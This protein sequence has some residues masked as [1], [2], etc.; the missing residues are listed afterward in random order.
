MREIMSFV[1]T[2]YRK[3]LYLAH[4]GIVFLLLCSIAYTPVVFALQ[5]SPKN[6]DKIESQVKVESQEKIPSTEDKSQPSSPPKNKP[7]SQPQKEAIPGKGDNVDTEQTTDVG[8]LLDQAENLNE[9][10][11]TSEESVP[12]NKEQTANEKENIDSD[13]ADVNYEEPVET[14]LADDSLALFEEE[15]EKLNEKVISLSRSPEDYGELYSRLRPVLEE[16]ISILFDKVA[17]PNIDLRLL[18]QVENNEEFQTLFS[19]I[20]EI[21]NFFLLRQ[22]LFD[23]ATPEFRSLVT[24][25]KLNGISEAKLELHYIKLQSFLILKATFQRVFEVPYRFTSAPVDII[26]SILLIIFA[27][28]LLKTWWAWAKTGLPQAR[29]KILSIRPRTT[30]KVR[31]AR[32][33]WYFE[34]TR[35]PIEWLIFINFVLNSIDILQLP[36]LIDIL[37][38]ITLWVCLTYFAF[39]FLS[40]MIERGKQNVLKNISKGQ[41]ASLKIAVWWAGWHILAFQLM[42]ILIPYGTI[43][44]WLETLFL[45]LILP[46]YVFF[47]YQWREDCFTF[48]DEERDTPD[49]IVKIVA[50]R[51]GIRGF[52]NANIALVFALYFYFSS[53]FLNL[54]SKVE[55]GRRITAEI[56]RKKLLND[57]TV[58]LDKAK[59][60]EHL[61]PKLNELLTNSKNS[62]VESVLAGPLEKILEMVE[63]HERSHV[64]IVGERGIGKTHFLEQLATKHQNSLILSCTEDFNQF[65]ES[66]QKQLGIETENPNT[67]DIIKAI[68]E[69]SIDLILLDNCHR[70]LTPTISGQ[71]EIRRLYGWINEL[72][73]L[74][75]WVF[76][77][78]HSS[79]NL[80]TALGIATGFYSN[81]IELK[82]WTEDQVTEL[83]ETRLKEADIEV[84]FSQLVIP[85]QLADIDDDSLETRNQTGIY[86]IIWGYADGNPAV[87]C[88]TFADALSIEND[89]YIVRLPEYPETKIMEGFDINTLLVLRVI[90]Q[91]GRCSVN[92]IVQNLRLHELIVNSAISACVAQGIIEQIGGRY[93]ISWLWFR[94]VSKFLARQ[95]LLSR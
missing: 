57:N 25:S 78:D 19:Q 77:F 8:S 4:F 1:K 75:L 45:F 86:R 10:T 56:Y 51:T 6:N 94:N 65:I 24:S 64:A 47:I 76:T 44:S 73:G 48:I 7:Q 30:G 22:K 80:L 46:I 84:D 54:I 21:K 50:Q 74:A 9:E 41:S 26:I 70:F 59:T 83:F 34:N 81:E 85:R 42:E 5:E 88:R 37:S 95:N 15:F 62:D 38:T 93:Q 49:S 3:G 87:A 16:R 27:I 35:T 14:F 32:A 18:T 89:K 11:N 20:R 39:S 36:I 17:D 13:E 69:Q 23:E 53:E 79:W 71:H 68:K 72:K 33:I 66:L 43:F 12:S 58:L 40:K 61:D 31:A 90:C 91:F 63:L 67:S 29:Q 82:K 2:Q 55:S 60:L 28:Y 52:I 92:G